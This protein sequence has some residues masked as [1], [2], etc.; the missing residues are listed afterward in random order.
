MSTSESASPQYCPAASGRG[1]V[2]ESVLLGPLT[3]VGLERPFRHRTPRRTGYGVGLVPTPRSEAAMGSRY[4]W[5]LPARCNVTRLGQTRPF[6]T[7]T[8]PYICPRLGA[9]LKRLEP[10]AHHRWSLRGLS[11]C[12]VCAH[13]AAQSS[14]LRFRVRWITRRSRFNCP[15]DL[16]AEH[17]YSGPPSTMSAPWKRCGVSAF[18]PVL[19]TQTQQ[20]RARRQRVRKPRHPRIA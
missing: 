14:F 7:A 2:A 9:G 19:R 20:I 10:C 17:L 11:G 3:G 6:P 15:R 1:A 16:G 12:S 13:C 18:C 8:E 4:R 5:R